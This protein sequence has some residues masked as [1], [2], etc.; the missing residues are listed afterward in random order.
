MD[1]HEKREQAAMQ[2]T[3]VEIAGRRVDIEAK[4]QEATA[5]AQTIA[6]LMNTF[7]LNQGKLDAEAKSK[8]SNGVPWEV[9]FQT[10]KSGRDLKNAEVLLSKKILADEKMLTAAYKN[11][12]AF[13]GIKHTNAEALQRG[14]FK[15][16]TDEQANLSR[17]ENERFMLGLVV[18]ILQMDSTRDANLLGLKIQLATTGLDPQNLSKVM[19]EVSKAQDNSSSTLAGLGLNTA[20]LQEGF[21]R[22]RK[23]SANPYD[24]SELSSKVSS[25]DLS[26]DN[27]VGGDEQSAQKPADTPPNEPDPRAD[28]LYLGSAREAAQRVFEQNA[29]ESIA[30]IAKVLDSDVALGVL[31]ETKR[32]QMLGMIEALM[33]QATNGLGETFQSNAESL[34]F[35][36]STPESTRR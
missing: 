15:F 29:G 32:N 33:A 8:W 34:I 26:A 30:D 19:A 6:N 28:A 16:R 22:L 36:P 25:D 5:E 27:T 1:L 3:M 10:F 17:V 35:T 14:L 24:D 4:A 31:T 13:E 7:K 12:V 23:G 11:K 21:E 2:K 18:K 20:S 9:A